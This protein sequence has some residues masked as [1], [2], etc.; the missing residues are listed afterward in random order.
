MISLYSPRILRN[1]FGN[2]CWERQNKPVQAN[3]MRK[4]LWNMPHHTDF[5]GIKLVTCSCWMC[6]NKILFLFEF[7][8]GSSFLAA[9]TWQVYRLQQWIMYHIYHIMSRNVKIINIA[10]S[11]FNLYQ[12]YGAIQP[13]AVQKPTSYWHWIIYDIVIP[14]YCDTST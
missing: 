4:N 10:T 13:S 6:I 1:S 9:K 7:W 5:I 12:H 8:Q 11:Q 2:I 3:M 14:V